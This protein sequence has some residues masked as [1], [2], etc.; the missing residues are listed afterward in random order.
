MPDQKLV[1]Q[2]FY[3][4]SR[5]YHPDFFVNESE[6][7]Q[8]EILELSTY[9]NK[10]Y[11]TF[12]HPDKL[13]EYMLSLN[14][15]ISESEKYALPQSFLVEMMDINEALM[16]LEFEPNTQAILAISTQINQVDENLFAQQKVL[17]NT[18]EGTKEPSVLKQIKDIYYRKKYLLRI[19]E[20]INKFA[21][22]T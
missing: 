22:R 15:E 13:I 3:E 9:N 19:R 1:K 20:S 4:L 18:Y 6:A 12:T 5:T 8:Q 14:G 16:E 17:F 21:T 11:Q 7:K 2:K 10:A